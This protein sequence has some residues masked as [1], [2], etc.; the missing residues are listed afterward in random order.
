[1]F[2]YYVNLSIFMAKMFLDQISFNCFYP[3]NNR[4]GIIIDFFFKLINLI[5][6][7]ITQVGFRLNSLMQHYQKT[8]ELIKQIPNAVY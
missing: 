8:L 2:W 7:T 5:L 6:R 1:M 4:V 3:T